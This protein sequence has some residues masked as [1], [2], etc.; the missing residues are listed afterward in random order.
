MDDAAALD[1]LRPAMAAET[2]EPHTPL[3][4]VEGLS[5][6]DL[7]DWDENGHVVLEIAVSVEA[8]E[9]AYE[10]PGMNRENAENWY[11]ESLGHF[12]VIS[13]SGWIIL[14]SPSGNEGLAASKVALSALWVHGYAPKTGAYRVSRQQPFHCRN[15]VWHEHGLRFDVNVGTK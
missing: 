12:M 15:K 1:C 6:A 7:A 9:A 11:A 2:A 10:F 4:D 3:N 13:G 8:A 5:E 14:F